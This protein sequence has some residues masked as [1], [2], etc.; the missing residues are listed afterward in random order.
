MHTVLELAARS[1]LKPITLELG[2]KSPFFFFF[3]DADV[4]QAVKLAHFALFF[5]QVWLNFF[6]LNK[7]I[8]STKEK[9]IIVENQ[10]LPFC[11]DNVVVL[12]Q[13]LMSMSVCM[14]SLF[15]KR[16]HVQWNVLLAIHSRQALNKAHR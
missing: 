8:D 11:R 6:F 3:Y 1:N 12:V 4:V 15:K 7:T 10:S 2:G 16:R 9:K 14:T 5:N 13:E